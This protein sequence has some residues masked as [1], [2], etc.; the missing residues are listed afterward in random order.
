MGR[1][2]I[3]RNLAA[4]AETQTATRDLTLAIPRAVDEVWDRVLRIR[5][6]G[7]ASVRHV[8]TRI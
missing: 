2:L 3:Q 8:W 4:S 5:V 7:G 6:S 1:L